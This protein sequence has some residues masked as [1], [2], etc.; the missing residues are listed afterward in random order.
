MTNFLTID[1]EEY[2][3]VEN[4]KRHVSYAE[5]D[6]FPSRVVPNTRKIL[7]LL[8]RHR[9]RATFFVLGWVAEKFPEL[10]REISTD[11]HEVASHGYRHELIFRQ[12]A[13]EFRRDVREGKDLL[14]NLIQKRVLGYRAPSWSLTQKSPWVYQILREEGIVY[15]SSVFP[16]YRYDGGFRDGETKPYQVDAGLWEFPVSTFRVAG[17]NIPF[18]GGGY[19]RLFPYRLI[20]YGVRRLNARG[21]PAMVYLH[22]WEFDPGQP[23]FQASYLSSFRHYVNL[24]TTERK[25]DRLLGALSFSSLDSALG[26]EK[27]CP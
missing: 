26:P 8:K 9:V 5:W 13:E 4:F 21:Q 3:Q 6:S 22:P 19:F 17:Q 14:E 11:G 10:V 24:H 2:F 16:Y 15:D 20:Q 25:L 7:A 1:V 27:G 12:T 18:A 23:R